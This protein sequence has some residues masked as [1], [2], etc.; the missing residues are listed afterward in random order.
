[1]IFLGLISVFFGVACQQARYH[2]EFHLK[3]FGKLLNKNYQTIFSAE[4]STFGRTINK[5][6]QFCVNDQRCIGVEICQIRQDLFQCR[7]CCEW[8]KMGTNNIDEH[9]GCK[10][11]EMEI[12][13]RSNLAA[14][15]TLSTV[16]DSNHLASNAVDGITT[17]E[18]VSG[19]ARIAHSKTEINPWLKIGLRNSVSVKR[20]LIH[21]RQDCCGERLQNVTINVT[22]NGE[23][24]PCGFYPG[25]AQSGDRILFLC[26]SGSTGNG[27]TISILSN[28][29]PGILAVCEVEVYN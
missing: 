2:G 12:E 24:Y 9:P 27:V 8:K 18:I 15:A 20:V 14:N 19:P 4:G 13:N 5:C 11:L 17:C 23:N 16:F 7:V 6:S 26:E 1:M 29:H 25:P 21:N 3:F 28:G 10:Y 22:Q